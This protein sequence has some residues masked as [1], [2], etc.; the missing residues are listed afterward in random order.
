MLLID[1][2]VGAERVQLNLRGQLQAPGSDQLAGVVQ[3][4]LGLAGVRVVLNLE[5]VTALDAAGLGALATV[6]TLVDGWGGRITLL[7]PHRRFVTL[8]TVAGLDVM[9]DI[10]SDV[11]AQTEGL[12]KD[13]AVG[14]TVL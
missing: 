3:E 8:L 9:F 11:T 4:S 1:R 12:E 14:S 7:N 6:R 5:Q 2:I 10:T 13:E